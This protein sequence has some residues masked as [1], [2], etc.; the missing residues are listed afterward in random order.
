MAPAI[1]FAHSL[2]VHDRQGDGLADDLAV[3]APAHEG[4]GRVYY[5]RSLRAA[6]DDDSPHWA[7]ML[8]QLAGSSGVGQSLTW[9]SGPSEAQLILSVGCQPRDGASC[10]PSLWRWSTQRSLRKE[11]SSEALDL[12]SEDAQAQPQVAGLHTSEGFWWM[13][14]GACPQ[15]GVF[16]GSCGGAYWIQRALGALGARSPSVFPGALGQMQLRPK[17]LTPIGGRGGDAMI[18]HSSSGEAWVATIEQGVTRWFPIPPPPGF[19]GS[20][21]RDFAGWWDQEGLYVVSAWT[22]VKGERQ[23]HLQSIDLR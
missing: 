10:R 23:M 21:A 6:Q 15:A 9:L 17:G 20:P 3:G 16:A 14:P 2:A 19:S 5:A 18:V 4:A 11:F 22:D 8:G 13:M 12:R 1:N 7:G